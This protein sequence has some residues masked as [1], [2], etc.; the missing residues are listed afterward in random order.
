MFPSLPLSVLLLPLALYLSPYVDA[1]AS[2]TPPAESSS[3]ISVGLSLSLTPTSSPSGSG[4]ASGSASGSGSS[5]ASASGTATSSAQFPSLSGLSDCANTCYGLAVSSS[6]CNSIVDVNCYCANPTKFASDLVACIYTKCPGDL[7]S[8]E[9]IAERFCAVAST[10]T[11]LSFPTTPPST[12]FSDPFTTSSSASQN[13][14]STTAPSSGTSTT[15]TPSSTG[16]NAAT[17]SGGRVTGLLAAVVALTGV[18]LA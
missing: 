11:L 14:S 4:S 3:S 16:T 10:S 12:T 9:D 8:A 6:K 5:N 17:A 15:T 18:A 1:A 13:S 7:S 2:L